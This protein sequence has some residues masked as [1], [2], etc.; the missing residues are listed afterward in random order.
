KKKRSSWT[1][2]ILKTSALQDTV[3]RME[4]QATH[5]EEMFAK[6]M[7]GKGLLSKIYKELLKL[8]SKKTTLSEKMNKRSEHKP[9][10]GRQTDGKKI[11][12][13]PVVRELQIKRMKCHCTP[14]RM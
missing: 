7:S 10:Q 2:L 13:F 9:H 11:L 14:R 8:N 3:K 6:H 1:L 5:Q 12:S 4:R